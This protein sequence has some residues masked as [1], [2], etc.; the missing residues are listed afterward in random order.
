MAE[1]VFCE[2]IVIIV[3]T[4]F[5]LSHPWVQEDFRSKFPSRHSR[6]IRLTRNASGYVKQL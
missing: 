4:Q 1:Y 6:D 5:L 2:V 3:T